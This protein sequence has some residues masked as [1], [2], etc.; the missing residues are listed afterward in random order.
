MYVVTC[1]LRFVLTYMN[2]PQCRKRHSLGYLCHSGSGAVG[3][4]EQPQ[5]LVHVHNISF[6]DF[7]DQCLHGNPATISILRPCGRIRKSGR[8]RQIEE[9]LLEF[10]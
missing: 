6:G 4:G 9:L 5:Q 7:N 3:G 1:P 8:Q 2:I 10:I